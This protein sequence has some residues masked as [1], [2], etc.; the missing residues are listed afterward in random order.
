[1]QI[2][3]SLQIYSPQVCLRLLYLWL[4][5]FSSQLSQTVYNL[6][7]KIKMYVSSCLPIY[8]PVVV[9]YITTEYLVSE[10]LIENTSGCI[11][12]NILLCFIKHHQNLY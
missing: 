8:N 5:L 9:L 4:Y 1:M 2:V 7:F 11:L 6:N 10:R 12:L 3:I